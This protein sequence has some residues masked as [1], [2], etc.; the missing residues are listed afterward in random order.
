VKIL[1]PC[2][3]EDLF[4]YAQYCNFGIIPLTG[5]SLNTRLSAL[6][7]V[8]EYLMSGLPI[9]CTNYENLSRIIY[10][11]PVGLIGSTFDVNSTRSIADAIRLMIADNLFLDLKPNALKLAHNYFNWEKEEIKLL[12]IY[13]SILF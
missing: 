1:P 11:N 4:N 7:K 13:E 12:N 8:S 9:I 6:N 5:N 3:Y 2:S 10:N